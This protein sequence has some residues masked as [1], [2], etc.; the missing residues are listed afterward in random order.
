M[1][2]H[3]DSRIPAEIRTQNLPSMKQKCYRYANLTPC[4]L[5][6]VCRRFRGTCCR[7]LYPEGPR[8]SHSCPYSHWFV[9]ALAHRCPS[10]G[11]LPLLPSM[12]YS[13][14]QGRAIAQEVSGRLPTAA[15]RVRSQ[16]RS[17]QICGGKSGTGA[18][19]VSEYFGS[20]CE[21]SFHRLLH[22]HHRLHHPGLVK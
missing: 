12:T 8:N 4:S 7:L 21:F 22:T 18:C 11:I 6:E 17:C 20:P 15:V 10:P 1:K 9:Q 3:Q 14:T 5:V 16:V 19:F 13:S 2:T